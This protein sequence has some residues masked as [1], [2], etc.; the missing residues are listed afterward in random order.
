MAK[1][2]KD[3][4]EIGDRCE[5]RDRSR[6]GRLVQVDTENNWC[7]VKWDGSGPVLVHLYELR[8]IVDDVG[9]DLAARAALDAAFKR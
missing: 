3:C 5:M 9:K 8:K 7:S 6:R 4:P 1:A 2:P